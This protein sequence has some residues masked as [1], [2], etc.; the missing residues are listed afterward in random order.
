MALNIQPF[1]YQGSKRKI[2]D[3]IL[4]RLQIKPK[5]IIEPFAGSAALTIAAAS[6]QLCSSFVIN[7]S[8]EPLMKLWK[9]IVDEPSV[10][11][12]GYTELWNAQLNDPKLFYIETRKQ[13]NA[14]ND[15]IKLLYLIN[16]SVKGAVRFNS[17]GEFNQ[18]ADNRRLGKTPGRLLKD[19][20]TISYLL[21]DKTSFVSK[22]YSY[23]LKKAKRTDFIYM[24]PPYLGTSS[25]KDHRYH[26]SLDLERF[27]QNLEIL[28]NQQINY[29]VSFDGKTGNKTY[30][31]E[32]PKFLELER[33]NINGGVS[34]QGTLNGKRV[35]TTESL[36]I[37]SGLQ[38]SLVNKT[39]I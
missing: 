8:Y 12:N 24:D 18:S 2:A 17:R 3:Q 19:I 6:K 5:R 38:R 15:P 27:I 28:N 13:F 31:R 16:R 37:S 11:I 33:I 4:D 39:I 22:D 7:D 21:K 25:G 32:L 9:L 14:D 29:M 36:Y 34:T 35:Y 20:N 26:Q 23:V 30:G 1:P 10:V